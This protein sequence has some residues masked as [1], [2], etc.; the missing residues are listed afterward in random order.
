MISHIRIGQCLVHGAQ[1]GAVRLPKMK[2][3]QIRIIPKEF[4]LGKDHRHFISVFPL[5][6][7][8]LV[9]HNRFVVVHRL[10]RDDDA[11]V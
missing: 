4:A 8:P 11:R 3:A 6:D 2:F 7:E 5:P 9:E 10:Q 1:P